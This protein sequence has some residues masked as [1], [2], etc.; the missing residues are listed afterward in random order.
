MATVREESW[1]IKRRAECCAGSGTPFKNGDKLMTRLRFADGEYIR[2]DY[3]FNWWNGQSLDHGISSW[4]SVFHLPPP[5]EEPLKKESAE[6]L[7]RKLVAREDP[8]DTNAVYILAV[9]LERKKI[10]VEKEVR[11][12]EDNTK[13]RVYEHRKSGDTFLIVDP[14]LKLAEIES[15][16]E[17]VVGLL[18]GKPPKTETVTQFEMILH[19]LMEKHKKILFPKR[20]VGG[21]EGIAQKLASSFFALLAGK[22]SP[23]R[24]ESDKVF[25]RFE[26]AETWGPLIADYRNLIER[27]PLEIRFQGLEKPE[28]AKR[29]AELS[30]LEPNEL[31]ETDVLELFPADDPR[32][33]ELHGK[34]IQ[35]VDTATAHARTVT[36]S[37]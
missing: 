12:R 25:N 4:K 37:S 11:T 33:A 5:P 23:W 32:T 6:S 3:L 20:P 7:L 13:V 16:Q 34:F 15:V 31:S 19:T 9:M 8:D 21:E 24:E 18:G 29:I 36:G 27:I 17:E 26:E 1:Q 35:A 10:L 2:E 22:K 30:L 28:L 14:E